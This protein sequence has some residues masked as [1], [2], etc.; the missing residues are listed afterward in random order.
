[1]NKVNDFQTPFPNTSDGM[2]TWYSRKSPTPTATTLGSQIHNVFFH[3]Y[4]ANLPSSQPHLVSWEKKG[5]KKITEIQM[6]KSITHLKLYLS[7]VIRN[8]IHCQCLITFKKFQILGPTE[9]FHF[10]TASLFET[11]CFII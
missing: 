1:M 3:V 9:C 11:I 2:W 4:I 5:V 7:T 6:K 10:N 8:A